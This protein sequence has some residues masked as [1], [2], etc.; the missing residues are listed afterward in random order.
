MTDPTAPDPDP[1]T[2]Q[3][4]GEQFIALRAWLAADLL[5]LLDSLLDHLRT[6][7]PSWP[8]TATRNDIR[9]DIR[10]D[11]NYHAGLLRVRLHRH[12]HHTAQPAAQPHKKDHP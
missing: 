11:L 2:D 8:A 12:R 10:D 6:D 3:P 7:Q 9:N 4:S 1:N 5:R